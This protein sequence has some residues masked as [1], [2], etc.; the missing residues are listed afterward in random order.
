M[1]VYTRVSSEKQFYCG[2]KL[3]D[4]VLTYYSPFQYRRGRGGETEILSAL[5]VRRC[6]RHRSML[7]GQR[8]W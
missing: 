5:S 2:D 4:D 8:R 3:I 6:R 1:C 7:Q